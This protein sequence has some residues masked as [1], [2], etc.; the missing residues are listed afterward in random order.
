MVEVAGGLLEMG[1]NA[2]PLSSHRGF[3]LHAGVANITAVTA[4]CFGHHG[5][6]F[7]VACGCFL[8]EN[9]QVVTF[10]G[11]VAPRDFFD[12]EIFRPNF[13]ASSD[14]FFKQTEGRAGVFIFEFGDEIH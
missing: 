3:V 6:Q 1:G 5:H 11:W 9:M 13:D 8:E 12:L 10:S 2:D 14:A 7:A 4:K